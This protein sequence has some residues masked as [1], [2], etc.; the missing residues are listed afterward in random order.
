MLFRSHTQIREFNLAYA[1]SDSYN[2]ML[3][4]FD[5]PAYWNSSLVIPQF[6]SPVLLPYTQSIANSGTNFDANTPA[7]STLWTTFPWS[8]WFDNY[9][10]SVQQVVI[11]NPGSGYL[12]TPEIVVVGDC[13]E[14]AEMT[15]IINSA[16]IGRAHV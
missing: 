4:D 14:P 9:A 16:E 5:V 8:Q 3:T 1:G 2:G 15:C 12:T 13:T 7:N 11:T 10:L 6:I